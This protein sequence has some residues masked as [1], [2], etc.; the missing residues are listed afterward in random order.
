MELLVGCDSRLKNLFELNYSSDTTYTANYRYQVVKEDADTWFHL[1]YI[2][3]II[4]CCSVRRERNEYHIDNVYV[5]EKWRGRG[6]A[7]LLL[8]NVMELIL[9]KHSTA[10]FHVF[11]YSKNIPAV[12]I[13]TSIFGEPYKVD[14]NV[15]YFKAA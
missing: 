1:I 6:Y 7:K 11:A 2:E 4:G 8:L 15:V 10:K 5:E 13:Y 12:K 14:K 9:K 3:E